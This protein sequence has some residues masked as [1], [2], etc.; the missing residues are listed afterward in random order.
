[1]ALVTHDL[2]SLTQVCN[3]AV[4]L[5]HGRMAKEGS[6]AEVAAAYRASVQGQSA[7]AA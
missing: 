1:M 5:D 4:W 7:A 2:D 3:R 6:C